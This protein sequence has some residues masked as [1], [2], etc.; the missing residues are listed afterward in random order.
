MNFAEALAEKNN[1][2]AYFVVYIALSAY[3]SLT[4]LVNAGK[5]G[6]AL[7]PVLRG[8]VDV[9]RLFPRRVFHNFL[10]HFVVRNQISELLNE[11][12]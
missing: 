5:T 4:H 10:R 1:Q 12:N 7:D 8:F 11:H 9:E 2:I 3:P 6:D